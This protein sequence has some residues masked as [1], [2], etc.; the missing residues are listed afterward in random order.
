MSALQIIGLVITLVA[1]FGY[2]NQRFI[3][4]P[5][6]VGITAIGVVVSVVAV[7]LASFDTAIGARGQ[8]HAWRD[9]DFPALLLHGVLGMLLFAGACTST[10]PT[11]PRRSGSS[12]SWRRCGVLLS[13]AIVGGLFFRRHALARARYPAAPLPAVRRADLADRSGRGAGG[14]Q[15]RRRSEKPRDAHRRR[16]PLQRRHRASSYS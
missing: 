14:A 13:T 2:F 9:I 12:S 6:A 5:D 1:V 10:S 8:G 11:S 15:A 4:L 3:K 16:K 7:I